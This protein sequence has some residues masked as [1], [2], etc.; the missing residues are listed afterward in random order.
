MFAL[1]M[2][3]VFAGVERTEPAARHH[4][5]QIGLVVAIHM[6][7]QVLL[8]LGTGRN[9]ACLAMKDLIGLNSNYSSSG[10]EQL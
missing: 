8:G 10:Q 5:R 6:T 9:D 2:C 1:K 3:G 7:L 4:A